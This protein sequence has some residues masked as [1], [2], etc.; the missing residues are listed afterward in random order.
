M[1]R[2]MGR[3]LTLV[4]TQLAVVAGLLEGGARIAEWIHPFR[5]DLSFRYAPYRM[6]RMEKAP[7]PLNRE[8]FRAREFDR[9]QGLFLIEF[10]GGSVCLGVG[11]NVGKTLPERLEEALHQS[12]F[13]RAAVVNLCQGGASSAQ[14]FAIFAEYGLPL[15]PQVVISFDG[16]NDLLHPQP[17]GDDEAPNLPYLNAEARARV[18]GDGEW[19]SHMAAVRVAARLGGHWRGR[20]THKGPGVRTEAIVGSYLYTLGLTRTLAESRG[21]LYAV[22]LQPTLYVAKPWSPQETKMWSARLGEDRE[23]IARQSA[24]RYRAA[25]LALANWGNQNQVPVYDLSH[26]FE[27]WN[28]NVYSD[29]VHFSGPQGYEVL[30]EQMRLRGLLGRIAAQYGNWDAKRPAQDASAGRGGTM[31]WAPPQ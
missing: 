13:E 8:G 7:W 14:E 11:T 12:G 28:G 19:L 2:A 20:R 24:T 17:V 15:D 10:L 31:A 29:S 21:A 4:L 30:F 27:H 1:T 3:R 26:A 25:S 22:I 5:P 6:L 18:D 9:Y 16:A 23:G